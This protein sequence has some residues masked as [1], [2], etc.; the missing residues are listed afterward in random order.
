MRREPVLGIDI[1]NHVA[2]N[3]AVK[4]ETVGGR[5]GPAVPSNLDSLQK[6][7]NFL[8]FLYV[9]SH[10][11]QMACMQLHPLGSHIDMNMCL[12]SF[13]E[14]VL[15]HWNFSSCDLSILHRRRGFA[16][17]QYLQIV[18]NGKNTYSCLDCYFLVL[19][20]PVDLNLAL[21][22]MYPICQ[23]SLLVFH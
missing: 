20:I 12:S 14:Q 22:P 9:L 23:N 13:I 8:R 7:F 4:L 21:T 19:D 10:S 11:V 16:H 17:W 6:P 3:S 1:F 2:Q 15:V 18:V 5:E